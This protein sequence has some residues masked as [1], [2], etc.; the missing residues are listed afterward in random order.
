MA[1][2]K[3]L[4]RVNLLSYTIL[5]QTDFWGF[6]VFVSWLQLLILPICARDIVCCDVYRSLNLRDP[7]E[8]QGY[9]ALPEVCNSL[10]AILALS[11]SETSASVSCCK[12]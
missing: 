2:Q 12:H 6:F 10:G 5:N 1:F 9:K 8:L 3:H 11:G 7:A 4:D